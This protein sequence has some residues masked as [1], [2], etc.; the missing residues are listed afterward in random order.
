MIRRAIVLALSILGGTAAAQEI[1]VSEPRVVVAPGYTLDGE[2]SS[3]GKSPIAAWNDGR[4]K[5]AVFAAR[6]QRDGHLRGI[7][8]SEP[9]A[10]MGGDTMLVAA[11]LPGDRRSRI[12]VA[13]VSADGV[14]IESEFRV[15]SDDGYRPTVASNGTTFVVAANTQRRDIELTLLSAKATVLNKW[16]VPGGAPQV[17]A[18]GERYLC[19]FADEKQTR[20]VI[21]ENGVLGEPFVI[22]TIPQ[23]ALVT[24]VGD[25]WATAILRT[26]ALE[27]C[28]V[29]PDKTV[30]CR[31]ISESIAPGYVSDI[32]ATDDAIFVAWYSRSPNQPILVPP[33]VAYDFHLTRVTGD[34]FVELSTNPGA[35]PA[36]DDVVIF[37]N[38]GDP[39]RAGRKGLVTGIPIHRGSPEQDLY[40]L[41]PSGDGATAF[42]G[43]LTPAGDA[44]ELHATRFID[45][46]IDPNVHDRVFGRAVRPLAS[47]GTNVLLNDG[48]VIGPAGD[49]V[50]TIEIP[51]N[52]ILAAWDGRQYV[53][54]TP[55]AV[56]RGNERL[57][58]A[59]AYP[60]ALACS[61]DACVLAWQ[62]SLNT[63]RALHLR[64][65]RPLSRARPMRIATDTAHQ[66][67]LGIA[68]TR[69]EVLVAWSDERQRL[70]RGSI[71]TRG[72]QTK[73][74]FTIAP[75]ADKFD[76]LFF[77]TGSAADGFLLVQNASTL[78]RLLRLSGDGV[79]LSATD[80][81]NGVARNMLDT[82]GRTLVLYE[83]NAPEKPWSS[84]RRG[85]VG[86]V[87]ERR[88]T[89]R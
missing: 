64:S 54:F 62:D 8:F 57:P 5:S 38:P 23:G 74:P 11:S 89:I 29:A 31:R 14:P 68:A 2:F 3:D 75:P 46:G 45:G 39:V 88:A 86:V 44:Y 58:V 27:L 9:A 7:F 37:R 72:G 13:R 40:A 69:S 35:P 16:A 51:R 85:F 50:K 30:A 34:A 24:A 42:W 78:T 56:H 66:S 61:A 32:V 87:Q 70:I 10:A 55:G 80:L 6:M 52:T 71:F 15:I 20:G 63:L 22:S 26:D 36:D 12:G 49:V 53:L 82:G 43:E 77:R 84:G 67:S 21:L 59:A 81:Q 83:R 41:L 76:L 28:A 17:A 65:D 19:T 60:S 79:I 48:R 47:D 1:P 25:S 33:P 73:K 4:T 18:N